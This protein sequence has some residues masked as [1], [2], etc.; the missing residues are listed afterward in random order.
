MSVQTHYIEVAVALPVSNTF[1]YEVPEP[2]R[3]W[4]MVGK[5]VLVPFKNLQVT[6]YILDL[7]HTTDQTGIKKILDILDD[8]PMFPPSMIPFFSWIADYYRY[9]IGEV[10]KGA[11][12]G[13]LN[14][15]QVETVSITNKGSSMLSDPSLKPLDRAMLEALENQGPLRVRTLYKDFKEELSPKTLRDLEQSGWVIRE[16]KLKPGRVRPK[17]ER[18]IKAVEK[19][20]PDDSLSHARR[21][22]LKIVEDHGEISLKAL[23]AEVPSAGRLVK[24]M[25]EDGFLTL[26]ERSVYRDPFG[27]PIAP[28]SGGPVLTNDQASVVGNVLDAL[29][30]GFQTYLLYGITGSGKT[31]VYMR[32]VAAALERD[33]EALILVPEIAL[34]SQ[35]ERLFRARFGECVALLH[36]GLSEGERFDQWMRIVRKEAKVAIGARSAIF[37]PFEHLGLIVVDE[38]HDD[39]YKQESKLRYH[40]RDL[41]VV[42]ARSM[43]AVALLGS[44]TP[45]VQSYYNVRIGKFRGLNLAKRIENR[46][47]P[48]VTIMDLREPSGGRRAKPF[49]TKELQDAIAETLQRKEQILLFLNR[50]GF[51]NYPACVL[52][53]TPVRCKNCDITMTL[54][55]EANAFKCHYCGY[56]RAQATGCDACGSSKI[57]MLGLGTERVEAKIKEIFPEARVARMDRDTTARKGAVVK[58]LKD[59]RTGAI[60]ILIGTQMVAKGHDYPNITLVGIICADLSLNFPDFR[61]GERTFQLLAQVAGRA[62]RGTRPG[63]VILQTFNPDHFCILTARDQDYRAFYDHEIGFR[64]TLKYPPF[65]RL[66]QILVIG[67]NKEQAA[68]YAQGLGEI[69]RGLQS[70]NRTYREKV[71]L[72][73]P[74]AAP[75]ARLHKQ[76]RWQLLLKGLK[77]GPLHNLTRDLLGRAER[78][79]RKS[80]VKVIVDV[81]PVDM[82]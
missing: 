65:S 48:E 60:D 82:L 52:C 43:D 23:N 26:V 57:K 69:C 28:D 53:G 19:R 64:K 12:P 77:P 18:Y 81:D 5:R 74:V 44:A 76:Y 45:S 2:L 50:R 55:Q 73:G 24:K 40:A 29:G 3:P 9:P 30:K 39:S 61:A 13:G 62:G 79:P 41:A 11:L 63:R 46:L 35:M 72:L 56:T 8:T 7:V 42:R 32:A 34:I 16:R 33:Q 68:K 71:K 14:I 15:T 59:L 6:G 37:A 21:N 75:L 17:T 80:G 66:I 31:E 20:P 38:E 1:T 67:K 51:A 36:S 78:T 70:K 27:E 58:I 4:A 49:I 47:L 22:I 10:I 25:A 54:H